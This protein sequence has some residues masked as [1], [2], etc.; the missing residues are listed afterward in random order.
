MYKYVIGWESRDLVLFSI[1]FYSILFYSIM[2]C[3]VI[4]YYV[5]LCSV[6]ILYLG[7][8]LLIFLFSC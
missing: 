2:F 6:D 4:F 3:Y 5:M 1:L 8:S 7:S